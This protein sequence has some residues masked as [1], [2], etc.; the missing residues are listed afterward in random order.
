MT[1][2]IVI[3]GGQLWI[4]GDSNQISHISFLSLG[5]VDDNGELDWIVLPLQQYF[6]GKR[7]SF[8]GGP[9]FTA[10]GMIW[11]RDPSETPEL[12]VTQ[13]LWLAMSRIPYGQTRS[14]AELG[15][16]VGGRS[17]ARVAGQACRK[18]PLPVLIPCHRVVASSGLG[19]F[20]PG[21]EV[22]KMLLKLEG[23]EV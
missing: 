8:P 3:P 6:A 2:R 18:N 10:K 21:Q 14:Y 15:A 1:A 7:K 16:L 17:L 20:T 23:A 4:K 5:E 13:R 22:K 19:G 12:S 11:S 9:Q